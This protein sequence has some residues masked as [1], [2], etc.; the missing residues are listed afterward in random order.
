MAAYSE[1]AFRAQLVIPEQRQ[2]YDYWRAH[3]DGER[4]PSR[5]DIQP[6]DIPPLL[7]AISLVDVEADGRFRVRLAGTRLREVYECELTGLYLDELG[8]GSKEAYWKSA[9]QRV[10][11]AAR[12]AQ[13]IARGP[14][15]GNNHMV[16][17]WIRLPLS[18]ARKPA[19]GETAKSGA[20][21]MILCYDAFVSLDK[22]AALTD[23]IDGSDI[24]YSETG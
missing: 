22:A 24:W 14:M 18:S 16:Q 15:H 7:P 19:S 20:V 10:V 11:E 9:Y 17:F 21:S 12:P 23:R 13:G 1:R 2:I 6:A 4:L 5:A 3:C 8:L